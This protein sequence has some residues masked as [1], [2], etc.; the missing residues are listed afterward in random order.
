MSTIPVE[1]PGQ[2]Q[3][4]RYKEPL[5][6]LDLQREMARRQPGITVY[7][8][9]FQGWFKCEC[10]GVHYWIPPDL[11]GH[12]LILHPATRKPVPANG[13][14]EIA[15]IYG[16]QI[17]QDGKYRG[18]GLIHSAIQI[19]A[20]LEENFGP[21][22]LVILYGRDKAEDDASIQR[23]K[24]IAYTFK[25]EWA[26]VELAARA[27]FVKRWDANP[28][29]KG[30]R[31]PA[32]TITQREA[33]E[34]LDKERESPQDGTYFCNEC[35]L[36]ETPSWDAFQRHMQQTHNLEA[37]AR[38]PANPEAVSDVLPVELAPTTV[39]AVPVTVTPLPEPDSLE[40]KAVAVPELE[41]R[42]RGRA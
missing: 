13:R 4:A 17:Q 30:R 24:K 28:A 19:A 3:P 10:Y 34:W 15:D 9:H 2:A 23:S 29:N 5:N 8:A 31:P 11:P 12:P 38:T 42:K 41:G 40:H 26:E 35:R 32:P 16:N 20:F 36:Y 39:P 22:G 1:F 33:I 37:V 27:E 21:R 6:R 25:R 18:E 14:L 7:M